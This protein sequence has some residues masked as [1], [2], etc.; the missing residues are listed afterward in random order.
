MTPDSSIHPELT[1]PEELRRLADGGPLGPDA[2]RLPHQLF[3]EVAASNPSRTAV[4]DAHERLTYAELDGYSNQLARRLRDKGVGPEAIVGI[5]LPRRVEAVVAVLAV[6]KAG[7]A[8]LPLDPGHPIERRRFVVGDAGA[9]ALITTSEW[10]PD[11]GGDGL[12]S[13][14]VD[15]YR[16]AGG[17]SSDTEPPSWG[18]P[19]LDSLAYVMYTSGSTGRPKGVMVEHRGVAA[20]VSWGLNAFT[21]EE[22]D[23]VLAS[24]SLGF[25]ISIFELLVPLSAGGRVV[26]VDQ[27]LALSEAGETGVTLVNTVPSLMATLLR[28]YALPPTVR[29]VILAG[30]P[31][32]AELARQVQDQPE[33]RRVVNAYGPTEDTIYSTVSDVPSGGRPSIGRPIPGGRAYVMGAEGRLAPPGVSGELLLG[34]VGLARGYRGR[35]DLTAERFLQSPGP[36]AETERIYRTGDLASW[37]DQGNLHHLGRIDEQVKIN[38]VRIEPAE[39]E[40]AL[41]RHPSVRQAVVLGRARE[42]G[43]QR[44]AAYMVCDGT[45]PERQELREL[46]R[47]TL[48]DAMVPSAF[49]SVDEMPLTPNG[50]LDRGRLPE[51]VLASNGSLPRTDT[52]HELAMLWQESL[53]LARQPSLDEDFFEL[54]GDSLLAFKLFDRV[55]E[56]FAADLSPDVLVEA[57]TIRA[58]AARIDRAVRVD[59]NGHGTEAL[60]RLHPQGAQTPIFYVHAVS[61]GAFPARAFSASLGP[62]QPFFGIHAFAEWRESGGR[63]ASVTGG[64]EDCLSLLRQAQPAGP[65]RLAGFSIGA[66]VAFEMACRLQAEGEEV[67]YLG[68]MDQ[69]APHTV[70]LPRSVRGRLR[71]LSGAGSEGRRPG[72]L[73]G[74]LHAARA[75]IRERASGRDSAAPALPSAEVDDPAFKRMTARLERSYRPNR[76]RGDAVIFHTAQTARFTGDSYL[77]WHRYVDGSL[78]TIRVRASDHDAMLTHPFVRVLAEQLRLSLASARADTSLTP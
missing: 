37:D 11:L 53:D 60:V 32:S 51:P 18:P 33:V 62:D 34:G 20:F 40:A 45:P 63:A 70:R 46:L 57:T 23:G 36:D 24:T 47:R 10:A 48:P 66:Y 28:D 75:A 9:S 78:D 22:L 29:T 1:G 54:G 67:Q 71:E 52:E 69:R 4:V 73:A 39:V 8:Y 21:P 31:L 7:G 49:M 15:D 74:W 65:Y 41:M 61:G 59:E 19:E 2:E 68:L 43:E 17:G 27:L 77:G 50:K 42:S 30:E 14:V 35:E 58:L 26:L 16:S 12:R 64:A 72:A 44:L 6:L 3:E 56:R 55:T 38:G 5:C 25:D 13:L 76:F